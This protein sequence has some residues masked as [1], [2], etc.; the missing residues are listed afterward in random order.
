MTLDHTLL[1]NG[2]A[3]EVERVIL[4]NLVKELK[5]CM[6]HFKSIGRNLSCVILTQLNRNI[7]ESD[8]MAEPGSQNFPKKKD[9][10][11]GDALFQ[12]SDVV[13]VTMNPFQNQMEV[14]GPKKW[15]TQGFLYWHFLNK[16]LSYIEKKTY[17]C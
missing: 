12:M 1:V 15:P 10:F 17:I 7:E 4:V 13:L 11:G 6:K 14:Y 9:I 5:R 2:A 16:N 8:R 3:N